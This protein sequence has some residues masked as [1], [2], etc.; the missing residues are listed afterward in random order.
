MTEQDIVKKISHWLD[1]RKYPFQV[2]N[3]FIYAWESDYWAMTQNGITR[4]FEIKISRSDYFAD[5]KKV[6]HQ[7]GEG[8]NYFYYVCPTDL[9]KKSEVDIRYGLIYVSENGWPDVVK[10]PRQLH[11]KT[12]DSWKMLAVKMYWK[13][14]TLWKEKFINK[15]ITRAE[16]IAGFNIQLEEIEL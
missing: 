7:A 6:K 8:A 9:I 13:F 1:D 14:R 2:A 11:D 15:E 5:A 16:Y 12:F 3:S 10:K 4:E